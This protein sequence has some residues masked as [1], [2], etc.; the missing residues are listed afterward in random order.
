MRDGQAMFDLFV[1]FQLV[2]QDF[3]PKNQAFPILLVYGP[4]NN[5]NK[6]GGTSCVVSVDHT[7][8][9][10][11]AGVGYG[12]SLSATI[13]VD[14]QPSANSGA[15]IKYR[16]PSISSLSGAEPMRTNVRAGICLFT[17]GC[18]NTCCFRFL[19]ACF[20]SVMTGR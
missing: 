9:E 19:S 16:D 2:G 14:S 12:G 7:H 8:V 20:F 18:C 4:S 11:Q 1:V 17:G 15:L 5:L 10:C 13:T 3:G 6:F